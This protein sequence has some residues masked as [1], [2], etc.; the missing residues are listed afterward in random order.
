MTVEASSNMQEHEFAFM[1][2]VPTTQQ[3][4]RHHA[5]SPNLFCTLTA[6]DNAMEGGNIDTGEAG[7]LPSTARRVGL[8]PSAIEHAEVN[9]MDTLGRLL[10]AGAD[11]VAPNRVGAV[12]PDM[13]N[14]QEG[15]YVRA[16]NE[17]EGVLSALRGP[18]P[19]RN[20]A[21]TH[22]VF[23]E[24]ERRLPEFEVPS[25]MRGLANTGR[26]VVAAIAEQA[27]NAVFDLEGT[28]GNLQQGSSYF[29]PHFSLQPLPRRSTTNDALSGHR[30][31]P[32]LLAVWILTLLMF[33]ADGNSYV[34]MACL[35]FAVYFFR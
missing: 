3:D 13:P 20:Q 31:P 34:S 10:Q 35:R 11:I 1:E 28:A 7:M 6:F 19:V 33:W 23:M 29:D 26:D 8:S 32:G 14:V 15:G 17:L 9:A 21:A 5:T 16:L 2:H 27:R 30:T 22:H 25:D 24:Y 18:D 12:D 4:D